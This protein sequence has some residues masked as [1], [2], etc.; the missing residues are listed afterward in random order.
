MNVSEQFVLSNNEENIDFTL[1]STEQY[2]N[3]NVTGIVFENNIESEIPVEGATVKVFT[4]D[5]IPYSHTLTDATGKYT[6]GNLPVGIYLISA[7]KNGYNLCEDIPI[8]ITNTIPLNINLAIVPNSNINKNIIYGKI[9]DNS[10]KLSLGGV[11]VLL[12]KYVDGTA[13]LINSSTSISDGEYI[14]DNIEDGDYQV[15]F[16]KNG[17]QSININVSLANGIK[18]LAD[19][20]MVSII[21]NI[22]NTV[23]GIIRDNLGN[24]VSNALVDL[25]KIE[26]NKE[27]LVATTY[28]NSIGKYMFGNVIDGN[29]LVKSK[30]GR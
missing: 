16:V 27:I 4:S 9:I 18:L 14:L 17:Y 2:F 11:N 13:T 29:Y 24:V 19:E 30:L 25:Y 28:T 23:S 10:T 22:N 21:G 5:G 15:S 1:Q 8:S 7:T 3:E 26:N 20:S 6:I 12:Y